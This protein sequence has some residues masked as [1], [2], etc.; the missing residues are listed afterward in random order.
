MDGYM[1]K[2]TPLKGADVVTVMLTFPKKDYMALAGMV[3]QDI[4][5]TAKQE[6]T[7]APTEHPTIEATLYAL[8]G[9]I[10]RMKDRETY[11]N[12]VIDEMK[13]AEPI[14]VTVQEMPQLFTVPDEAQV[15]V[16]EVRG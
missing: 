12:A 10:E 4:S 11:L 9:A 3:F 8:H 5:L 2:V 15:F 13:K 16:P 14:K 1:D 7:D 6:A